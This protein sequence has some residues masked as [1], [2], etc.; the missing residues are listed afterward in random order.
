[1]LSCRTKLENYSLPR[2]VHRV[3]NTCADELTLLCLKWDPRIV[4]LN[5][6][7]FE[8]MKLFEEIGGSPISNLSQLSQ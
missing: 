1:M 8:T 2:L 6:P 4:R 7:V 5:S 3:A